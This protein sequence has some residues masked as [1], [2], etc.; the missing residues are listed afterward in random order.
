MGRSTLTDL[1]AAQYAGI[2]ARMAVNQSV[3]N[4]VVAKA[5]LENTLGADLTGEDGEYQLK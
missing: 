1:K 3:Y 2:Q 5:N 4:Y